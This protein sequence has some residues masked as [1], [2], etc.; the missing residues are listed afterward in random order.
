MMV[1]QGLL[2]Y[3][4]KITKHWPEYAIKD[5]DKA[6]TTIADVM[7]HE[8]GLAAFDTSINPS[9]VQIEDIK[10][11]AVGAVIEK[12]TMHFPATGRRQYHAV[13]R[14]WVANEVFRR[15]HPLGLTIGEFLSAKIN[16]T[17]DARVFIGCDDPN[18]CPVKVD[19]L[20]RPK[21]H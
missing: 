12:Q 9:N 8:A 6:D 15:I 13:T 11:N 3:N 18:Y 7:R 21:S 5:S 17:L 19:G 20:L 16:T 1:D 14:G 10:N 2:Q 4:D